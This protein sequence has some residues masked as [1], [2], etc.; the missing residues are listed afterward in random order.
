MTRR[1]YVTIL[2]SKTDVAAFLAKHPDPDQE[3][4]WVC[5]GCHAENRITYHSRRTVCPAC[6]SEYFPAVSLPVVG[7]VKETVR[8]AF[9]TDHLTQ[10]K[11]EIDEAKREITGCECRIDELENYIREKK[12]EMKKYE[13]ALFV[14]KQRDE[15]GE[16][17]S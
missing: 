10:L 17:L 3:I 4:I 15:E 9:Y 11:K 8:R 6:K 12:D 1:V 7:D 5:P 16:C 14:V 2:R 13:D